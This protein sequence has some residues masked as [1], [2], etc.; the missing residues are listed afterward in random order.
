MVTAAKDFKNREEPLF[1]TLCVREALNA[2]QDTQ[3]TA[4]LFEEENHPFQLV[5]SPEFYHSFCNKNI[6]SQSLT[7][8]SH[9]NQTSSMYGPYDVKEMPEIASCVKRC[10]TERD[11]ESIFTAPEQ[12]YGQNK[13][14]FSTLD[15]EPIKKHLKAYCI[16]DRNHLMLSEEQEDTTDS[17]NTGKSVMQESNTVWNVCI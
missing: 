9:V 15:E 13:H 11:L 6:I 17:E 2:T 8:A 1:G 12:I 4:A 16:R 5:P 7:D 10:S 3:P 14:I